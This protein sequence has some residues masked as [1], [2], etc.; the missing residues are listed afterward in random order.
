MCVCQ[1]LGAC[2]LVSVLVMYFFL[3]VWLFMHFCYLFFGLCICL[4]FCYVHFSS[5]VFLG[6]YLSCVFF[7]INTSNR[8]Q[9]Y[10]C[11][12]VIE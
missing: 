12:S 3:F 5:C 4:H 11:Q 8:V 1:L 9:T 7:F 2:P 10:M 6:E